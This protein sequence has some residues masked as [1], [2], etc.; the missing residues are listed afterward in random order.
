MLKFS[1]S[2]I[3]VSVISGGLGIGSAHL[4]SSGTRMKGDSKLN[5]IGKQIQD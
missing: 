4:L 1:A 5:K 2:L 3:A